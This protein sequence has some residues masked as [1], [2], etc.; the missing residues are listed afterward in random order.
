MDSVQNEFLLSRILNTLPDLIWLKDAD[1]VYVGCNPAFSRFF[2]AS[3]SEIIGKTD[4]DF[5]DS[6]LADSFREH[7]R[8]AMEAGGPS[9][10]EE[11]ITFADDGHR[12]L[13]DT[14][15]T[16]MTDEA[17][18]LIGILGIAREVTEL[19]EAQA[20]LLHRDTLLMGLSYATDHILSGGTLSDDGIADALQALGLLAAVDRAYIFENISGEPGSRGTISQRYEWSAD[21]VAP[22][23]DNPDLQDVSWDDVAPRWYDTFVAGD[24]I[25]GNVADF[26]CSPCRSIPMDRFGDS[27]ALTCATASA[28]GGRQKWRC[29]VRWPTSFPSRSNAGGPRPRSKRAR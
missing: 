12:A 29:S 11:W 25:A 7:D 9:A 21:D 22:Q 24:Y 17:G 15:K 4:Y 2:G 14:V 10:N 8:L 26:R 27:S 13:V 18:C 20:A 16:P 23:I 19:R 28:R 1:G 5:V 3:E 6:E